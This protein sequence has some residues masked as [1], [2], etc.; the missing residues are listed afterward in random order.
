MMF[1]NKR[2]LEFQKITKAVAEFFKFNNSYIYI[3]IN[4]YLINT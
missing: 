1:L 2:K 3:N 4:I